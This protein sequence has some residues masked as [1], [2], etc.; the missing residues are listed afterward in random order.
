VA[1]D[2]RSNSN[3]DLQ[4]VIRNG[5]EKMSIERAEADLAK[6]RSDIDRLSAQLKA[7]ES[8]SVKLAHY[9]EMA[10]AYEAA[11]EAADAPRARSNGS[12]LVSGTIE[13]L[14]ERK[15]R[16]PTTALVEEL[17]RRGYL[18]GGSNKVG[19]L[20]GALSRS[21]ALTPSRTK[22]WGLLEW[23]SP[24][25]SSASQTERHELEADHTGPWFVA[26]QYD[27]FPPQP[28]TSDLDDEIPF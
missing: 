15:C 9:I 1:V 19:N 12:P 13:I 21:S 8:R 14:R 16:V 23:D 2:N 11:S 27:P 20:S 28:E 18:I 10:R 4:V 6:V 3:Y 17:E 22:G 7:A 24:T 25:E 26:A 5:L